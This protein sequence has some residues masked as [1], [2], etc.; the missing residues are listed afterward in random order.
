MADTAQE[1]PGRLIQR[2]E[3]SV[4]IA[5]SLLAVWLHVAYLTHAGALWRDEAGGV[6]LATLSD[7]GETW[8]M[9]AHDS[10]PILFPALVRTW[11]ALGLGASDFHLRLLGFVIG[12][13]VLGALWLN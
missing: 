9:L 6:Q 8:R 4:A 7:F 12:L 13:G 2:L 11:S 1:N 10:F 3:W 5:V